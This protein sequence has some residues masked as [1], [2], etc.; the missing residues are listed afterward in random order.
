MKRNI[1]K[2]DALRTEV[3][4]LQ[5]ER[6]KLLNSVAKKRA[7]AKSELL[8]NVNPIIEVLYE[9]KKYKNGNR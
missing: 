6:Q 7:K 2:V 8:K 9:R 4:K 5:S 3:S 1:K